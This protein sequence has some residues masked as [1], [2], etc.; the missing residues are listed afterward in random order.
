MS[1]ERDELERLVHELPDDQVP[2]ALAEL[3]RHLH[4]VSERPWPPTWF[5]I[6]PGDGTA[7]GARADELLAEGFGQYK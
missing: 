6:A 7:V 5:G 4:P 1:A 2:M 3:R